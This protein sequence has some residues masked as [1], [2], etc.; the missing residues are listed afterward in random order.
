VTL[1]DRADA[2]NTAYA[3]YPASHLRIVTERGGDCLYGIWLIGNDY[4]AKSDLY[5]AYPPS[6]L[7][8]VQSLF[9]D[10]YGTTWDVMNAGDE[11]RTLHAFSGSL[12]KGPYLRV[13]VNER[14]RPDRGMS[15]YDLPTHFASN[16]FVLTLADPP[17]SAEDAREYDTPMVNRRAAL[18]AIALVT[19]AHGHLV[20]LDTVWPM[21]S[22]RQWRTV[23]RIGLVRST[24]HRVRLVSIFERTA[25]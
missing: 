12:P 17:Y 8:R 9:P 23:G 19:E 24:N 16:Q 6:Y 1:R 14:R 22:K 4:R 20:W 3:K 11:H 5:G 13:D 10:A 21:F 2:Y 25:A 18:A 7:T 15:V